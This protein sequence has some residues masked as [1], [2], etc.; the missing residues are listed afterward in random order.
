MKTKS[1][2]LSVFLGLGLTLAFILL[3]QQAAGA[4]PAASGAILCVRP[5]GGGGC[6]TTI[7]AAVGAAIAGDTIR[8]AQGEYHETVR[9]DK[10]LTLQG[11]WNST[12][13]AWN[14]TLYRSTIDAADNGS[15]ISIDGQ[16]TPI[17][18]TI[19]GFYITDVDASDYLGWGGGIL[20]HG[21]LD[22]PG[23][24]TIRNNYI[25]ENVA[26]RLNSCQGYGGGIYLDGSSS[27]ELDRNLVLLNTASGSAG[28]AGGG[29]AVA[30]NASTHVTLT[31][32]VIAHNT[33]SVATPPN[34]GS[35][36]L[37]YSGSCSLIHC[38]IVDNKTG[39]N[40]GEG[41]RI[42]AQGGLNVVRNSIIVGHD[43]GLYLASPA[44]IDLDYNNYYDNGIDT[45][46]VSAGAGAHSIFQAPLFVNRALGNYHL[47]AGSP[48]INA[49]DS[50]TNTFF[51]FDSDPRLQPPDI[52]ADEFILG[53]LLLPL[54]QNNYTPGPP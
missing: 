24:I 10:S 7:Q 6:Y 20:A 42:I 51:D 53:R 11:G 39:A 32:T 54:M 52:G 29:V 22:N 50:G 31:N 46:G 33:V 44:T 47:T 27:P 41:V 12:F 25:S 13:T 2:L 3:V 30:V 19:E 43:L 21:A 1:A 23:T 17:T 9:V 49:G 26:C 16:T 18:V 15:V 14:W 4:A 36:V 40:P 8:V 37:C 35:G 5:G 34:L 38:T 48:L 45:A 28:L